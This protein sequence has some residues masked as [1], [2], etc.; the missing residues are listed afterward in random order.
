ML[1][2]IMNRDLNVL[3][4]VSSLI[5]LL[6]NW[7]SLFNRVTPDLAR[8][9][10]IATQ[11]QE[12]YED[13]AKMY[14]KKRSTRWWCDEEFDGK[15][16]HPITAPMLIVTGWKDD[17]FVPNEGL[18]V[19]NSTIAAPKKI[20]IENHGHAGGFELPFSQLPK[21]PE[22]VWI[23][24]KVE[25]WFDHFFKGANNGVESEPAI[26][27]YRDWD[28]K[29]FGTSA[30]WPPAG[31][32]DVSYYLGGGTGFR[33]GSLS[34]EAATASPP[35]LLVNTGFCGSISMPYFSD[36]TELVGWQNLNLPENMDVINMPF[37]CYSYLSEP[38][39]NDV[40]ID[41]T[42]RLSLSCQ[43]SSQ[44]TQLNPRLYE[45]SPDGKRTF[46]TRGWYEGHGKRYWTG[47]STA[48][49]P[50]EMVACC[51]KVKAGD[52][53]ELRTSDMT[54]TWPLWGLSFIDMLH[55]APAPSSIILPMS[56]P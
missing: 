8:I 36:A 39:P 16:E 55:D 54:Q 18:G 47:I 12:A 37:Q 52:R 13:E 17:L 40:V 3:Q 42:P 23:S 30:Q 33:Q 44:F 15:V 38:M 5:A 7:Q 31:T 45:V 34:K 11:R 28:P 20:I 53:L 9:Y 41:G 19:F 22:K 51:H 48:D 50:V 46:I 24:Q 43:S 1:S 25:K 49:N 32:Q 26:S 21:D 4:K 6:G 27:Y 2:I 14:M 10:A 29:D 35:G 56:T